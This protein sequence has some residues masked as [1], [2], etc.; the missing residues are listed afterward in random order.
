MYLQSPAWFRYPTFSWQEKQAVVIGAGIAGCQMTWHLVQQGWQVT[1]IDREKKIAQQASGNPAGIISAKMTAQASVGEDFYVACFN[2]VIQQLDCLK[3]HHQGLDWHACGLLQLAHNTREQ[4]RWQALKKRHFDKGFLQLVERQQSSH[5]AGMPLNYK[6]SYFPQA[7]WVNPVS[8]CETLL[9]DCG[10]S[11]TVILENDV[12]S[13]ART[14]GSWHVFNS[15]HQA[16]AASKVLIITSGKD[17][18]QFPQTNHL[19]SMPV[20]GQTSI[21][22]TNAFAGQLK[23]TIGH[24]GYL[25]PASKNTAKLSFGA[26]FER[27]NTHAEKNAKTDQINLQQLKKYLPELAAS[28]TEVNSAHAA[29]RMTTP[30]RFPYVGGL[31]DREFYTKNYHDLHH[32]KQYKEYPNAQ[33]LDGLFVLAGLG[34][35][36]L[37]SSG[38]CAKVLCDLLENKALGEHQHASQNQHAYQQM[39]QHQLIQEYCHPARYLLKDLK[40][41]VN[42]LAKK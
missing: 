27:H 29:V 26:S 40:R 3:K 2:Y 21:A 18:N 22:P 5:I 28:F 34:S 39:D 35:R 42:R 37:S 20:A 4:Q 30:D 7:G 6:S 38:L 23:T 9:A 32:G 15:Q 36:G 13:L 31:A 24:Q 19:P 14:Q 11:C 8:F 12:V 33:Y 25:T 1:L 41:G 10:A 16:I 17:L